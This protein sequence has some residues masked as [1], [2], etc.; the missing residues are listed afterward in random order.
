MKKHLIA[1]LFAATMLGTAAQAGGLDSLLGD[2][3]KMGAVS[4]LV[5]AATISDSD[6]KNVTQQYVASSDK[7]EK[8]APAKD[9]YA[10]RLAK[11]VAKHQNEDGMKLNF[12]VYL[13]PNVNAFA[14]ADGSVRVYSGLMDLMTDDELRAVIGHEIGHVKLTHSLNAMRTAYLASAGRNLAASQ[15]GGIKQMAESDLGALSE[16]LLNNSFSR[17]QETDADDYG[18]AFMQKHKYPPAAMESAFRKLAGDGGK[19]TGLDAM[20]STHPDPEK[21]ANRVKDKMAGK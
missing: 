10:K 5:S 8:V 20:L 19:Q 9:K 1:T 13:S 17:S 12:K 6:L 11:L 21:R 3:N 18:F 14:T 7:K 4:D 2:K 15:G 16:A